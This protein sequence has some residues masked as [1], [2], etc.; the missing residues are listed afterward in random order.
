MKQIINTKNIILEARIK[1]PKMTYVELGKLAGVSKQRVHQ[2]LK[3]EGICYIRPVYNCIECNKSLRTQTK[4][5]K[6]LACHNKSRGRGD[7]EL[8]C[9]ACKIT[10][11]RRV[12]QAY[13]NRGNK[14]SFCSRAC[15]GRILGLYFGSGS[16][17]KYPSF[18]DAVK[19]H[20]EM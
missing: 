1:F 16:I 7:I 5:G 17:N 11:K 9:M 20:N 18:A 19:H 14:H 3:A 4:T 15:M 8:T 13:R 10:F 12:A 2:I 6:C